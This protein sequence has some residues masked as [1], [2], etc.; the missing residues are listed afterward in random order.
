MI[1]DE[2]MQMIKGNYMIINVEGLENIFL[3]LSAIIR[4][5]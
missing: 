4:F 2:K 1:T 5:F 3:Y